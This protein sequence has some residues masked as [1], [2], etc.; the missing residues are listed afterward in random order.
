MGPLSQSLKN[1]WVAVSNANMYGFKGLLYIN[2][3]ICHRQWLFGCYT[4]EP[5]RKRR[6]PGGIRQRIARAQQRDDEYQ[7]QSALASLLLQL[8]AWGVFSPQRVQEIAHKA[9]MDFEK[10]KDDERVLSDL[11]VLSK[12]GSQGKYSNKCHADLMRKT[13]HLPA[14]PQPFA[15][16]LPL[17]GYQAAKQM[18]LLP[19]EM[20][21]AIYSHYRT[22]W[23]QSIVP[24]VD[25]IKAFWHAVRLHPQ[26]QGHPMKNTPGWNEWTVP[27][28]VHGD[29]VPIVGIG[30]GWNRVM[31]NFAWFSLAAKG[32]TASCLFWIWAFYDKLMVGDLTAGT[33]HEFFSI[34]RWSFEVLFTGQWPSHDHRGRKQLITLYICIN[35][36]FF[37]CEYILYFLGFI[38]IYVTCIFPNL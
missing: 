33:L 28:G 29:G 38:Y 14:L 27:I 18:M 34:L 30:K 36:Y 4:M 35:I 26:M 22:T 8:F 3:F 10:A 9:V 6:R 25:K 19:H 37:C 13:E 5:A 2:T 7:S 32:A 11:I 20:F 17:K 24:S 23:Q 15:F 1:T 21:S 31:T 12:I 16:S